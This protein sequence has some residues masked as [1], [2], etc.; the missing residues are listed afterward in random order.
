LATF[1]GGVLHSHVAKRL[2][3]VLEAEALEH[4]ACWSHAVIDDSLSPTVPLG[5]SLDVFV[6][7]EDAERFIEEVR[8]TNRNSRSHCG[9][10]S[11]SLRQA[12]GTNG[13]Y[14]LT[15]AG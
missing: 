9:S 15:R 5:D 14:G 12:D 13:M 7:C 1:A 2:A 3:D 8:V 10:R 6:R 4:S 11:A